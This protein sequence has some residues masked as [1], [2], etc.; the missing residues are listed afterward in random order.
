MFGASDPVEA[1]IVYDADGPH[2]VKVEQSPDKITAAK[3]DTWVTGFVVNRDAA[4]R[5]GT[6]RPTTMAIG[7]ES[8]GGPTTMAVGEEDV[9]APTTM[10][11][12]EEGPG[13]TTMATGEEAATMFQRSPFG[14]F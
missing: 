9:T 10:A 12:G 13:P 4:A 2:E 14:G 8:G 1:V 6:E 11:T 5:A 7:E 3:P